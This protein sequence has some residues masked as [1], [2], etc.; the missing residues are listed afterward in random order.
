ML[1]GYIVE[2]VAGQTYE[3][4]LQEH[5]FDALGMTRSTALWFLPSELR[6]HESAGYF[7][8]DG[9]FKPV[10]TEN[11]FSGQLAMV[12]AGA[13]AATATDMARYMI[14]YLQGG[15]YSD[16]TL[17][18]AR[19]LSE[20]TIQQVHNTLYNPD[21]RMLGSAYGFF[22]FS[23]NGQWTLGH[24]GSTLG[25][26]T[27]LLLLPDQNLG[28][29]VAYNTDDVGDLTRQHF[30][31][32][33]AF[34]DHYYPASVLEPAQPSADFAQ[35][36]SQFAGSYIL[37][38][39]AYTTLEKYRNIMGGVEVENSGDGTL[40]VKS[41]WGEWQYVEEAPLYFRQVDAPYHMFF[42]TDDQG[43]V[44][45]M[46]LDIAPQ[47]AFEK[48][49]WY[50]TPGFNMALLLTSFLIFFSMIVVAVVRF[51]RDRRL[52]A[53]PNHLPR[54]VRAAW[55]QH[56]ECAIRSRFGT[57]VQPIR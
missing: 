48:I 39:S 25:Y 6:A 31:F 50:E 56:S 44:T 42:R 12:P 22:D 26:N 29:Y 38:R 14:A 21:P 10:P 57:V 43:H 41:P 8:T 45:Y 3:Q 54:R 40:T 5:I 36:A 24:S 11:D 20:A 53:D 19:I 7:Y 16:A 34:F 18:D 4:Y 52:G 1:A 46:F 15:H 55:N 47:F 2:R 27:L 30:G 32:Q 9:A 28:V 37:A 35:R 13:H 49:N 17:A 23:D 51:I 33:R